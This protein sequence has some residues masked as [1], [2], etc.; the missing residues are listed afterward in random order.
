MKKDVLYSHCDR[1]QPLLREIV[2]IGVSSDDGS[3]F[4]ISLTRV[5]CVGEEISKNGAVYRITQVRHAA[6]DDDGRARLGWHALVD[7]VLVPEPPARQRRR[8]KEQ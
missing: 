6:V 7:A 1:G 8:R 5:P 4:D 2:R 3:S